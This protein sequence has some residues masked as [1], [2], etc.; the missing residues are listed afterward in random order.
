MK[1]PEPSFVLV[2]PGFFQTPFSVSSIS[3]RMSTMSASF[4]SSLKYIG[5]GNNKVFWCIATLWGWR[6]CFGQTLL[7][8]LKMSCW[9]NS[10]NTLQTKTWDDFLNSNL[11]SSEMRK[12]SFVK[13]LI[14]AIGLQLSS[15]DTS[16]LSDTTS[17]ASY[18]CC[19][20]VC[21]WHSYLIINMK[22][23]VYFKKNM[24][25]VK[26]FHYWWMISFHYYYKNSI[27]LNKIIHSVCFLFL[28]GVDGPQG[29]LG[30]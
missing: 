1:F 10:W 2:A 23:A 4:F 7:R 20:Y 30:L 5:R 21:P 15:N 18:F 17:C 25:M 9:K 11:S 19:Q 6:T 13:F 28:W 12:F 16:T 27:N 26:S 24:Q 29:Y 22:F 3:Q 14:S 8:N